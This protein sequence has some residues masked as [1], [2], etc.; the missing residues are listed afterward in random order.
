MCRC[1]A[2][3]CDEVVADCNSDSIRIFFLWLVV[4]HY[5]HVCPE[6]FVGVGYD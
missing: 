4:H 2:F 3:V 5:S 6:P 1:D